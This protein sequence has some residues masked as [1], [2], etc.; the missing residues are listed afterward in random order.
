MSWWETFHCKV[1][2]FL[3]WNNYQN[4]SEPLSSQK[5]GKNN[6]MLPGFKIPEKCLTV[7]AVLGWS[8]PSVSRLVDLCFSVF[9]IPTN[10][11]YIACN[12]LYWAL[13]MSRKLIQVEFQALFWPLQLSSH[14]ETNRSSL[15]A[16]SS[17]IQYTFQRQFL[18]NW[19]FQLRKYCE[20]KQFRCQDL[21][22]RMMHWIM[23]PIFLSQ[24]RPLNRPGRT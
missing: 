18:Q 12:P 7:C 10:S 19:E 24:K 21:F 22:H 15:D 4:A 16:R 9:P 17:L 3:G 8:S 20:C 6:S 1:S 23:I 11:S 14:Q 13:M 5:S 2:C